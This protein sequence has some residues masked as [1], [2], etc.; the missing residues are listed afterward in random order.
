MS[1]NSV[2]EPSLVCISPARRRLITGLG[3]VV[4][5]SAFGLTGKADAFIWP[6]E[7]ARV[8]NDDD[9]LG[10]QGGYGDVKI[11]ACPGYGG[12]TVRTRPGKARP[13]N[14]DVNHGALPANSDI[15]LGALPGE[16]L[17]REGR[18]VNSY[19][20]YID[21]LRL[22]NI[23]TQQV[24]SAHA[25][26]RGPVW[27]SMPPR[28]AWKSIGPALKLL[29]KVSQELNVPVTEVVSVFRN[30]PYN[31]RCPGAQSNSW[32]LQNYAVDVKMGA[33]PSTVAEMALRLRSRG[34]FKGGIGRYPNF[35]HLDTR[36]TNADW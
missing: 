1:K 4:G 13:G 20:S 31:A 9:D 8:G 29:D 30:P 17:R 28:K 34:H 10:S 25:K 32:H 22:Q 21:S 2:P 27:N 3:A 14:D 19:A 5:A 35:T 26:K 11:G 23:T 7:R 15:N 12:V 6:W 36:G 16:W 18:S 24:I 33:K